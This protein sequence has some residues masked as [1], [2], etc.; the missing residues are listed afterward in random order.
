MSAVSVVIPTHDRRDLLARA[1]RSVLAQRGIELHVVVVD[2]GSADDTRAMVAAI[3]DPRVEYVRHAEPL[4]VS[5]AR[6]SGIAA[7]TADWIAFLDDDDLWAPDKLRLQIHSVQESDRRWSFGGSVL[8][9]PSLEIA[10]AGPC[11]PPERV[12]D[13][14]PLRNIVPGGASSVVVHRAILEQVGT[15]DTSL[16]HMAD[17]DLW[18]RIAQTGPPAGV[19]APVVAY[20][21]HGSNA[22]VDTN[23]IAR[24]MRVIETRYAHLRNGAG[25]DRAYVYRW[26]AWS[27]LRSGR[28]RDAARAYDHATAAGD[29]RSALRAVAGLAY[30][31]ILDW[32]L[33][34]RTDRA[35]ASRAA[36]WLTP[37]LAGV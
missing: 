21:L 36:E 31:G 7:A 9:T 19:D 11:P 23:D 14:L 15:F 24:E 3:G 33:R 28:R 22:S 30:P 20:R 26:I 32:Q 35:Y 4:G 6:N 2:D 29:A 1:L 13:E 5:A 27:A 25:L 34:R 18:I 16:R 10:G 37:L 17:W 12:R 8:L